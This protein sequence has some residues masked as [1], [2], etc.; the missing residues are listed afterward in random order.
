MDLAS[1]NALTSWIF[2]LK[3]D[4]NQAH[5]TSG[6]SLKTRLD[7]T[8]ANIQSRFHQ[9]TTNTGR[10]ARNLDEKESTTVSNSSSGSRKLRKRTLHAQVSFA[11]DL[12]SRSNTL[13][14]S[15]Q[16]VQGV[17]GTWEECA[18]YA[19]ISNNS[20]DRVQ[21]LFEHLTSEVMRRRLHGRSRSVSSPRKR[22]DSV[23]S[24]F[25]RKSV[26]GYDD[27]GSCLT[28]CFR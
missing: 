10:N 24:V 19:E 22:I 7:S 3:P 13:D 15:S 26:S 27:R 28:S 2:R 8:S 21:R 1:N 23:L 12:L 6:S 18:G 17:I 20:V 11:V 16:H 9:D 5:I 4:F 14:V 25:S